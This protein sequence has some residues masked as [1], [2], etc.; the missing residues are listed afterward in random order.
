MYHAKFG[1][2]LSFRVGYE[3][4]NAADIMG[5]FIGNSSDAAWWEWSM[6]VHK[7][8]QDDNP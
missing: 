7:A 3:R 2:E 4:E 1:C 6:I 8:E 5:C